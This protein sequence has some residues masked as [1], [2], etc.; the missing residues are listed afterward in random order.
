MRQWS[1]QGDGTS[2]RLWD[3]LQPYHTRLE[4]LTIHFVEYPQEVDYLVPPVS[5]IMAVA[6]GQLDG[7]AFRARAFRDIVTKG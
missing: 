3:D 6:N 1:S 4:A 5:V 7:E 2:N